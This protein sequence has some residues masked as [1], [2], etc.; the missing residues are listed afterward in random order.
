[1]HEIE[2][3]APELSVSPVSPLPQSFLAY[4]PYI[5]SRVLFAGRAPRGERV[6]GGALLFLLIVPGALLYPCL[7]FLL[8]EP[9]EGRYAEI[10]REML[11]RGEWVVPYL[12]G[13]PY[14]DKPPLF[15]WLV[16]GS[17]RL[18]GVHDWSA[19]LV[20]ALAVH[21][22]IIV[23][24]LL[25]RR[26][27]GERAAFWGALCL[28]LA[29]GLISVGRLLVLDGVL[30][31]WVT[32]SL[33]AALEAVQ[34]ERLHWGWWLVAAVASALG[35]LTKGPVILVLLVPPFLLFRWLTSSRCR[36]GWRGVGVFATV[37]LAV[38]LPWYVAVCL[39]LPEFT[40]H[41]LWKHN[42]LRFLNPFD[43]QEPIWFYVPVVLGGLFPASLLAIGWLRFLVSGEQRDAEERHPALG[44]FLLAGAWCVVFFSL[45]GSK[46]VTYVLPAFPALALG[47]GHY[48]AAK[49]WRRSPW[50]RAVPALV[51]ISLAVIHFV[52]L[53]WY[54]QFRSPMSRPETMARY[55]ADT[56]TPVVCYPRNCDSVAFYLG[57][58][59][60]RSWREKQIGDLLN[61]LQEQP[62]TVVLFTHRHSPAGLAY[63]LP[64]R[65]LELKNLTSMSHSWVSSLATE[66]CLMGVVE[67]VTQADGRSPQEA[68]SE[69]ATV[70]R[71]G[72]VGTKDRTRGSGRSARSRNTD[73]DT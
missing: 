10:P 40:G 61:F 36:V 14:L 65:G 52:A 37:L 44:F 25:G 30:T 49:P 63:F 11:A 72:G 43:H 9:D 32:L 54:A 41:F 18:F 70:Q 47:L 29:P 26:R 55:C 5:W 59:D 27:F 48:V 13:E 8:F 66:D 16:M 57:R 60:F 28:A 22:C 4:L 42:V 3:D 56:G 1:M 38:C 7:S 20:P 50:F 35:V 19:R 24:Y 45:S 31:L 58:D 67:R 6:R 53:P 39:R 15:Y 51:G 21:A 23:V 33:F 71:A 68:G 69:G 17:Y 64:A 34:H 2:Q 46:L 62:R 73:G 12:Q